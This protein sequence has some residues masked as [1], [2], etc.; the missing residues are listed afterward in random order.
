MDLHL[1][2]YFEF[3]SIYGITECPN[4]MY[5]ETQHKAITPQKPRLDLP[6]SLGGSPGEVGVSYGTLLGLDT[7]GGGPRE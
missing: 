4:F 3:M 1:G 6:T 5:S 2:L 7:V